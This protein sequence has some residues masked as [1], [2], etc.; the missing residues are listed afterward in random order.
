MAFLKLRCETAYYTGAIRTNLTLRQLA[1]KLNRV[2]MTAMLGDGVLHMRCGTDIWSFDGW[3]GD[4]LGQIGWLR[5]TSEGDIGSLSRKLAIH[6]VR[7]KFDHSR[8]RDVD[9]D[10]VR[11][12]TQYEF[13]W[14]GFGGKGG[15]PETVPTI[16][17]F[18]EQLA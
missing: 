3:E 15:G 17:T 4:G 1:S 8:P 16:E 12:V 2:G 11:C 14:E 7:H 18:D 10:D 9:T 13:R 5:F 6:G